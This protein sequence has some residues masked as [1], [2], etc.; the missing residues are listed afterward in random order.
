MRPEIWL[1]SSAKKA[2]SSRPRRLLAKKC[3]CGSSELKAGRSTRPGPWPGGTPII[4]KEN[5]APFATAASLDGPPSPL[6]VEI[7]KI[8]TERG[9]AAGSPTPDRPID[10]QPATRIKAQPAS[11]QKRRLA[12]VG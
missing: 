3:F 12:I 5:R 9:S 7:T 2:V 4:C 8:E 6:R 11:K 10:A 1:A